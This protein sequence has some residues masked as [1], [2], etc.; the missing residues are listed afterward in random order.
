M[1]WIRK[2]VDK[3]KNQKQREEMCLPELKKQI[4][5]RKG[6]F[7]W[8]Y[9]MTIFIGYLGFVI[10]FDISQIISGLFMFLLLSVFTTIAFIDFMYTRLIYYLKLNLEE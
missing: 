6:F 1:S 2:I 10:I 4:K 7:L 8:M 9:C 3:F 5:K